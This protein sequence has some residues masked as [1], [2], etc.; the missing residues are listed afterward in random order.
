MWQNVSNEVLLAWFKFQAKIPSRF[1]VCVQGEWQKYTPPLPP[2]SKDEG[3]QNSGHSKGIGNLIFGV[4]SSTVSYLIHYDN[5]LQN[6]TDVITK[7]NSCFIIKCD[8]SLL[9]NALGF[10]LQNATVLLQNVTV[11]TKCNNFITKCNVYYKLQ[12]Y[13]IFFLPGGRCFNIKTKIIISII[14]FPLISAGLLIS[15][16]L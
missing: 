10:L 16:T 1:G 14:V 15:A 3:L 12:Q 11:I 4:N 8:R 7:C 5:L 2:L 13:N 9:Q 6:V